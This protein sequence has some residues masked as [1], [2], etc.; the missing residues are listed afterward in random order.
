MNT[1][2]TTGGNW[3]FRLQPGEPSEES[4]IRLRVLTELYGRA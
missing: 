4:A 1:P 2:G 3:A